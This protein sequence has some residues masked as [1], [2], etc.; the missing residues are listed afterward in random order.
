VLLPEDIFRFVLLGL[1]L[2]FTAK[3]CL[4]SLEV[5]R[6]RSSAVEGR[7]PRPL[8]ARERLALLFGAAGA[9]AIL[10]A[11]AFRVAMFR[12]GTIVSEGVQTVRV[13]GGFELVDAVPEGEVAKGSVVARFRP[14]HPDADLHLV[15]REQ[16]TAAERQHVEATINLITT[17]RDR[18]ERDDLAAQLQRAELVTRIEA[19]T[20]RVRGELV[21]ASTR[22]DAAARQL[23]AAQKLRDQQL[24]GGLDVEEK[25]GA[26]RLEETEVEKLKRSLAGLETEKR[27]AEVIQRQVGQVQ[28]AQALSRQREVREMESRRL[29]A[30]R[31]E[32]L[33]DAQVGDYERQRL[34]EVHT[35]VA[36][37]VAY[38]ARSPST[39]FGADPLLVI[40]PP[41]GF[42]V[43]LRMPTRE[44]EALR[45]AG[46]VDLDLLDKR[47]ID[48]RFSGHLVASRPIA[49]KPSWSAVEIAGLPPPE[50]VREVVMLQSAKSTELAAA[51]LKWSPPILDLPLFRTGLVLA[52]I[53]AILFAST[54]RLSARPQEDLT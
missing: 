20:V 12:E 38:R 53:A 50:A 6:R 32:Q 42:R 28:R 35:P 7:Q 16:A 15:R 14:L 26:L 4:A 2:G 40:S 49:G 10:A 41:D 24:A 27:S 44:V 22:R 45:S 48:Q 39:T 3:V 52:L 5:W 1:L 37:V 30:M 51:A 46:T 9:L 25:E 8:V 29:E 11:L 13:P 34:L 18:A 36:G 43:L 21:Q 31:Q 33:A 17:E 54:M 23:A 47:Y 19:D